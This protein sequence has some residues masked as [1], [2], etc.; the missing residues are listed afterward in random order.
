MPKSREETIDEHEHE[1]MGMV[2]DAWTESRT[3]AQITLFQRWIKPRVRAKLGAMY[4]AA[5][6]TFQEE[7]D[8]ATKKPEAKE[9]FEEPKKGRRQES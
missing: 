3:G 6:T 4:D 1:I 8:K 7:F 9:L 2:L 5:M